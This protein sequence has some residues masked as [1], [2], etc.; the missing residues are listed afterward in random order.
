[1]TVTFGDPQNALIFFGLF[2]V[3]GVVLGGI[4]YALFAHRGTR[5]PQFR[6]LDTMPRFGA[7]AGALVAGLIIYMA[8]SSTYR[9]FYRLEVDE[10][11][12]RLQYYMPQQYFEFPRSEVSTIEKHFSFDKWGNRQIVLKT[13]QGTFFSAKMHSRQFDAAWKQLAPYFPTK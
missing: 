3:I 8:W 9:T 4:I 11:T 13:T 5:R 2:S 7:I 1:M 12:V 10:D 6:H